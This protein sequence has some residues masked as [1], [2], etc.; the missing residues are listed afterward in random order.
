MTRCRGSVIRSRC[1]RGRRARGRGRGTRAEHSTTK[2][3]TPTTMP[4]IPPRGK[5]LLLLLLPAGEVVGVSGGS[6]AY[7]VVSFVAVI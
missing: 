7:T 6:D 2:T 4:R 1:C 5:L 3:S